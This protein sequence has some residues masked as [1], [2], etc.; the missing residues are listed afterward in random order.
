M[1]FL[2]HPSVPP[3]HGGPSTEGELGMGVHAGFEETSIMLHLRPELV[4]MTLAARHIPPGLATNEHVRFGGD[5]SFGWTSDDFGTS[6]VIG[7]P[8]AANSE[9]GKLLFE[10]AVAALGEALAEV[11]RFEFA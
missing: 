5:V 11:A 9:A 6:G 7:D 4:D 1:T 8:T 2:L 10:H 3:D